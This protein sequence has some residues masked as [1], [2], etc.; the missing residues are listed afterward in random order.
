MSVA[1]TLRGPQPRFT[2]TSYAG[3]TS[4]PSHPASPP[5]PVRA[6]PEVHLLRADCHATVV[7]SGTQ[8]ADDPSLTVHG[9]D[10]PRLDLSMIA[11]TDRQPLR[12]MIVAGRRVASRGARHGA[13]RR[14]T[15]RRGPSRRGAGRGGA[16]AMSPNP[17]H[18]RGLVWFSCHPILAD[19]RRVGIVR[20]RLLRR[21]WEHDPALY[22]PA[23]YRRACAYRGVSAGSSGRLRRRRER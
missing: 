20:G 9:N 6:G 13:S 10:D 7:G 18:S 4:A 15:S 19:G 23:R 21:T 16:R 22:A 5:M 17:H 14:G 12:V 2:A 3:A 1:G 11:E 8:Q